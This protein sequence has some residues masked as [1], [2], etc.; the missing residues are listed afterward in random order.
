MIISFYDK[1]FKGLQNNASLVIDNDSYSLTKRPVELN[2]LSC[3]CEAFTEDIQPTFLIVSNHR[4]EY[5]Y[6]CLAG[7]PELDKDNKTSVNG[8]DLKTM[9]Q[10]DVILNYNQEF[11]TV[12]E[13]LQ[14]IFNSWLLQVNQWTITTEL[15]FKEYM[16][17]IELTDLYPESTQGKFDAL[18]EIQNYL[19]YYNLYLDSEIDLVNKKVRFVIG[20]TLYQP[21]NIKLWEIGIKNYGKWVADINECQGY[22]VNN[23]TNEWT[24]GYKWILTSNNEITVSESKRDIYPIKRKIVTSEQSLNDANKEA[25]TT[26]LDSLFNENIEITPTDINPN[27]ETSFEVYVK[28]GQEKY[29]SLPCGELQYNATGLTKVVIGYRYTG[30]QFI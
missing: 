24:A 8:T 7:V 10:S 13:V 4:G 19:K 14:Y 5:I 11:K 30:I 28:R 1:D 27:F 20:K 9:L 3:V 17:D 21:I 12:Q 15:I 25:L 29:K 18:S 6:G 23:D 16:E 26:L 2:E 22:L